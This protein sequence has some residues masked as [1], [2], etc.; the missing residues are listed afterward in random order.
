MNVNKQTNKQVNKN[1]KIIKNNKQNTRTHNTQTCV[2]N[3]S[4]S[5]QYFGNVIRLFT[6][7]FVIIIIMTFEDLRRSERLNTMYTHNRKHST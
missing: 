7:L 4:Q 6:S 2:H 1:K 3:P 5:M